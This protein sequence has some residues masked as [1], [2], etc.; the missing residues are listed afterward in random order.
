MTTGR[1]KTKKLVSAMAASFITGAKETQ[2][3]TLEGQEKNA[4]QGK[5]ERQNSNTKTEIKSKRLNLLIVPSLSDK[6]DKVAAMTGTSRNDLINKLIKDYT[7]SKAD[8]VKEYDR[9]IGKHKREG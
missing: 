7:D 2:V 1:E 8:L 3:Q 4:S 5:Y 6:L 9:T